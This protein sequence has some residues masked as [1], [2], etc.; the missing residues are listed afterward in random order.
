MAVTLTLFN[1]FY[2]YI[3]DGTIDLENDTIKLLLVTSSYAPDVAHDVLADVL[4]SPSPEVEAMASPSNGYTQGGNTLSGS[5]ITLVDSPLLSTWDADNVTWSELDA[6]FR[7][8]ILYKDGE[9][10]GITD[11]LIAYIL[12]DD[13][14]ADIDVDGIDWTL[15]WS[16]NGIVTFSQK[17]A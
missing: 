6:I 5:A 8:G 12:L 14:P 13:T 17:V 9:A 7:Y 10:N 3:A 11:P 2:K 15:Q 1:S 16:R 4:T